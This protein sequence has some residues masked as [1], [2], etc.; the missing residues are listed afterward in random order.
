MTVL[1]LV[2]SEGGHI[3]SF[4]SQKFQPMITQPEGKNLIQKCLNAQPLESAPAQIPAGDIFLEERQQQ[5]R[6]RDFQQLGENMQQKQLKMQDEHDAQHLLERNDLIRRLSLAIA[7]PILGQSSLMPD[8]P[9]ACHGLFAVP[10]SL[11][12]LTNNG[13]SGI[14]S[15][16]PTLQPLFSPSSALSQ[17]HAAPTLEPS[18]LAPLLNVDNSHQL[19]AFRQ[20]QASLPLSSLGIPNMF[21]PADTPRPDSSQGIPTH[22]Y[23]NLPFKPQTDT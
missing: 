7:V 8:P 22:S 5:H 2:A 20:L 16:Q 15:S 21:A 12:S 3:F 13:A 14:L 19:A 6:K 10:A 17:T 1:V 18:S 23:W 11:E 4:G 9:S